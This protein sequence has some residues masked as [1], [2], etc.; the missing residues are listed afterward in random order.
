MEEVI[1]DYPDIADAA[2]IGIPHSKYGEAPRAYVVAKPN[3]TIDVDKLK[4]YVRSKVA[5]YKQLHGGK[6]RYWS[7]V[8]I[9]LCKCWKI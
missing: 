6:K 7:E 8:F 1:R 2:V 4:D 5:D 9:T 3:S